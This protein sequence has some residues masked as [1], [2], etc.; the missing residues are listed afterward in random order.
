MRQ[1][2]VTGSSLPLQIKTQY[3][4][5]DLHGT[6]SGNF[7]V[8]P[9]NHRRPFP[10]SGFE[11]GPYLADAVQLCANAGDAAIFPMLYGTVLLQINRLT[12]IKR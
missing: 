7:T 1:I 6:D 11:E 10:E 9:G 2:R 8:V 5:T 12:R 3:F 4:L